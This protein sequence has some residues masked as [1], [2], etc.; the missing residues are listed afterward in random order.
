[1]NRGTLFVRLIIPCLITVTRP[2]I[3]KE[4]LQKWVDDSTLIFKGTIVALDS[5][6]DSIDASDNPVTVRVDHVEL[7]T[8]QA[9]K[10]F[11]SLV[12]KQLT[13][14]WDPASRGTMER[15]V[16]VSAVFFVN[17]LSPAVGHF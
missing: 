1:M 8:S 14:I 7:A 15:R 13:A 6:V 5:N 4:E 12:G 10:N 11:G 3:S 16:G 9:Q 17:P 2:D